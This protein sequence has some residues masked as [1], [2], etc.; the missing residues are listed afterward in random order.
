MTGITIDWSF[1]CSPIV[2][3]W[4]TAQTH[5]SNISMNLLA[6][7]ASLIAIFALSLMSE[8]SKRRVPLFLADHNYLGR[9]SLA[10][11]VLVQS[12]LS[13][14]SMLLLMTCNGYIILAVILGTSAGHYRYYEDTE[15]A[16]E[17]VPLCP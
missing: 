1:H 11:L 6:F 15:N 7:S 9:R 3:S 2:L 5:F 17:R 13:A 4:W 10:L 12:S 14:I 16:Y 8:W